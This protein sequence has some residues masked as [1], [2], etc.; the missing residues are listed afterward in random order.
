MDPQIFT[1]TQIVELPVKLPS[2]EV[3]NMTFFVTLLD[4]FCSAV[5]GYNWLKQ[6]N[7]LIDWSS[8]YITFHS[9]VHRGQ[10]L[11]TPSLFEPPPIPKLQAPEITFINAATYM[12]ASKLPRFITFQ[13]TFPS[14]GLSA[15]AMS[16]ENPTDLSDIPEDH[17]EFTDVFDKKKADT[18]PPHRLYDLKIE[19]EKGAVPPSNHMYLL[20]LLELEAL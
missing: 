9:A 17:H 4:S 7:L 3:F 20:S 19:T 16:T 15:K 5:L 18:L 6:C 1:I 11:Q 13:M 2:G 12:H 10:S 8:G 14:K